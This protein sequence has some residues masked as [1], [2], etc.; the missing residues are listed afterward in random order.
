MRS[1]P[2]LRPLGFLGHEQK[3]RMLGLDVGGPEH[4]VGLDTAAPVVGAR[5]AGAVQ[6]D[7]ERVGFAS[8]TLIAGVATFPA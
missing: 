4:S 1:R 7:H 2:Q 3:R 5:A 6:A 8:V